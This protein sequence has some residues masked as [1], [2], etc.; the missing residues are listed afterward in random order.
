M[1]SRSGRAESAVPVLSR[2]TNGAGAG[3]PLQS[4]IRWRNS[5]LEPVGSV[6]MP[7]EVAPAVAAGLAEAAEAQINVSR[8]EK[9]SKI[10]FF[11]YFNDFNAATAASFRCGQER[12]T[13]PRTGF[14]IRI[15]GNWRIPPVRAL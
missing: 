3:S 10:T 7:R 8:G 15:G 1:A 6:A 14:L 4:S 13:T 2:V 9:A 5:S 11:C 12:R